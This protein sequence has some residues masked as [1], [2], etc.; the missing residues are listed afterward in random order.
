MI[1][2][3]LSWHKHRDERVDVLYI[4]CLAGLAIWEFRRYNA[5]TLQMDTTALIGRC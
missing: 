4:A 5:C 1:F 3:V 2:S